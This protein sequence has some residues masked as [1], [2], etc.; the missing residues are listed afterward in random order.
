[1]HTMIVQR[2]P[3]PKLDAT[4]TWKTTAESYKGQLILPLLAILFLHLGLLVASGPRTPWLFGL[5]I[6]SSCGLVI[7]RPPHL[8]PD[9]SYFYRRSSEFALD[10]DVD[11][12]GDAGAV[13]ST[14][15]FGSPVLSLWNGVDAGPRSCWSADLRRRAA[16]TPTEGCAGGLL[17]P[18]WLGGQTAS[19]QAYAA[20]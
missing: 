11:G 4:P 1:M 13:H 12:D 14:P 7:R 10:V 15:G 18:D 3:C 2:P 19:G 17:G 8:N 5:L 9:V 6:P 16:T 20:A